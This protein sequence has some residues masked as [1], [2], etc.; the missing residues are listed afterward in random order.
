[1]LRNQPST[2]TTPPYQPK[3]VLERY[4]H[5]QY[6]AV[7]SS[8]TTPPRRPAGS[9]NGGSGG[10]GGNG[11]DPL[12]RRWHGSDADAPDKE[13][14]HGEGGASMSHNPHPSPYSGQATSSS[15]ANGGGE[16]DALGRELQMRQQI[17]TLQK[18]LL[19]AQ[20]QVRL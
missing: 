3:S 2:G 10:S 7:G 20:T 16:A 13:N 1:M 14:N 15:N 11:D 19:R 4:E 9:S 6:A 5:E 17:T 8:H 18:E 12:P